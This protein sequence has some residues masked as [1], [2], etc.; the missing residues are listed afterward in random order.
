MEEQVLK[1]SRR[2][3]ILITVFS[4][5]IIIPCLIGGGIIIADM[6][7]SENNEETLG[8]VVA[9]VS[10][11]L[12]V[13]IVVVADITVFVQYNNTY[14]ILTQ[15]KLIEKFKGKVKVEIPYSN[16]VKVTIGSLTTLIYCKETFATKGWNKGAK[17]F[18]CSISAED[19]NKLRNIIVEYNDSCNGNIT[20]E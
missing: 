20:L 16:I 1:C 12:F 19:C 11:L 14:I 7:A 13:C 8:R 5:I 18:A 2:I 9:L 3:I 17:T 15:C 4:A 6:S 10:I